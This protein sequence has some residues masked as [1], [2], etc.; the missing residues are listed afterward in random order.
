MSNILLVMTTLPDQTS[1]EQLAEQLLSRQLAACINILPTMASL[2]MWKGKLEHGKEHL[3][4]IKTSRERYQM[5]ETEIRNRHPYELPEII[6]IPV[7]AGLSG[8]LDW[9][10]ENTTPETS[11]RQK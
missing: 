10:A 3:L 4:L 5:L 11:S 7:T 6:G 8:Y 1:A 9:I 2:Y